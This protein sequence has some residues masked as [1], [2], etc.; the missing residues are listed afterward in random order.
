MWEA[1]LFLTHVLILG[2][3]A[4]GVYEYVRLR[5]RVV[6]SLTRLLFCEQKMDCDELI[7]QLLDTSPGTD[8][9]SPASGTTSSRAADCI[10][11]ISRK[12]ERLAALAAGGQ[13]QKYLGTARRLTAEQIDV[14]DDD[15]IEKLYARY[16]ARLGAAMTKTL[17][18]AALQLYTGLASVLL[19]IPPENQ[20]KL[21]ADL[22]A[23]PFVGHALSSASCELYHRYGMYLAPLTAAL[24]TAKHCRF[25]QTYQGSIDGVGTSAHVHGKDCAFP[26]TGDCTCDERDR[27][28]RDAT[29]AADD[30]T[31]C[32]SAR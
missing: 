4:C 13:A 25:E 20:P 24:T 12:R 29:G 14:M 16:E 6:I 26:T 7:E 23:D 17:G 11:D 10:A 27:V 31:E 28:R 8:D 3:L 21:A 32:Q 1:L 30:V 5:R 15:E 19:P 2:V 22:E 9:V 18:Q